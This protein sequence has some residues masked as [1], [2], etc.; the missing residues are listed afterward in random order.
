MYRNWNEFYTPMTTAKNIIKLIPPRKRIKKIA[1]ICAGSGN[2]LD[3]AHE[4]WP[5]SNFLAIDIDS[6]VLSLSKSRN[7]NITTR[8]HDAIDFKKLS[9]YFNRSRKF[10]GGCDLVVANPPFGYFRPKGYQDCLSSLSHPLDALCRE[11]FNLG[12]IESM[13]LVSNILSL[14]VGGIFAAVLPE[15][16]FTSERWRNFR[17]I[18]L[19]DYFEVI[20][21]G[22]TQQVFVGS[23]V[24]TRN[25]IAT[26]KKSTIEKHIK[27][28]MKPGGSTMFSS[29]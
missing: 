2:L 3:A 21:I 12:R 5:A 13:M 29:F 10:M 18:F 15:S 25:F 26:R 9:S 28:K 20:H 7:Y 8:C 4:R 19:N 16:F 1:D 23:G 6:S 27:Y 17:D 24:R 14:K 22:R 11:A